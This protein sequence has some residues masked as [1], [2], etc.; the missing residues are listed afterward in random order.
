MTINER[1]AELRAAIDTYDAGNPPVNKAGALLPG[2]KAE[3]VAVDPVIEAANALLGLL[4]QP[5]SVDPEFREQI[6]EVIEGTFEAADG[7][8]NDHEI[9]LLQDARDLLAQVIHYQ[10][11]EEQ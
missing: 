9:E 6:I 3:I 2:A 5:E 10:H 8:S 7:D 4:G 1:A 11:E